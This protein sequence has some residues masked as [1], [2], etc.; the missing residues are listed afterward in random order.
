LMVTMS[1][2]SSVPQAAKSVSQV[3]MSDKHASMPS[4]G[5]LGSESPSRAAGLLRFFHQGLR[6]IGFIEGENVSIEYRW[7]EG[8]NDRLAALAADLYVGKSML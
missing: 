2:K 1:Q 7:A 5:Y 3:L 4:I 6:E 8:R